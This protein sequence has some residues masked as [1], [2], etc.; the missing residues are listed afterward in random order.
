MIEE[1]PSPEHMGCLANLKL[2]YLHN[3]AI[4]DWAHVGSLA[5]VPQLT[6]L[7]MHHNPLSEHP[8]FRHYVVNKVHCLHDAVPPCP[9]RSV[10]A[11]C[12][13]RQC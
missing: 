7:T 4:E 10:R 5:S 8:K 6:M 9:S 13:Q 3:N 2:L 12:E 11:S 1:L